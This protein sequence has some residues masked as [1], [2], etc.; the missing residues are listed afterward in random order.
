MDW[1]EVSTRSLRR[2][3]EQKAKVPLWSGFL[4]SLSSFISYQSCTEAFYRWRQLAAYFM[5]RL[6]DPRRVLEGT[7]DFV[8]PSGAIVR[9]LVVLPDG[10]RSL[11]ACSTI[12]SR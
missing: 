3:L 9:R 11:L 12:C 5:V 7:C 6:A 8:A 10:N 4:T 2:F 1:S